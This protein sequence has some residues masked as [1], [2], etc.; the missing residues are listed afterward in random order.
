MNAPENGGSGSPPPGKARPALIHVVED[1]PRDLSLVELL[2]RREGFTALGFSDAESFLTHAAKED[3]K[4][5][6]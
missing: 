6:V 5:V 2:L 4:S 1:D 3:R